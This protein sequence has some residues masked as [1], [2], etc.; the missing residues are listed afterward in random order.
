MTL[1]ITLDVR[2]M[3]PPEPLEKVM[4]AIGDFVPGDTL[5]V[6]IDCEPVPLYRIL[7]RNG[8]AWHTEPGRESLREI[9]I[10]LKDP[11]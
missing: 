5:K 4:E 11:A 8:Y 1:A 7:E 10:W 2:G 9:T 6:V 3:S